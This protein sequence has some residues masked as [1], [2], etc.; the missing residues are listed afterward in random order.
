MLSNN[1]AEVQ[2]KVSPPQRK[3]L[4]STGD[5][6]G[7]HWKVYDVGAENV[8]LVQNYRSQFNSLLA[9]NTPDQLLEMLR[10]K[11]KGQ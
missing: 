10:K 3:S 6:K 9:K 4:F 11:V 7:W 8:S 1:Q 5:P 2:A